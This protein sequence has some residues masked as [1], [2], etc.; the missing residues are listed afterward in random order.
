MAKQT[1]TVS[2]ETHQLVNSIRR[3][4]QALRVASRDSEK[5]VGLSAAQVFVLQK[6]K[7]EEGLSLNDL[8][9]RT[10]THQSSVSVVVQRLVDKRLVKRERSPE[11]GRQ[12]VLSMT[13]KGRKLVASAPHAKQDWLIDAL[14]QMSNSSRK[15]LNKTFTELLKLA[16]IHSDKPAPMLFSEKGSEAPK[17]IKKK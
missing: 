7:E 9:D 5:T 16:K 12:L 15:Q 10:L 11:D 3:L 17:R 4:V 13:D 1:R 8:A 2:K 6:L 14:E